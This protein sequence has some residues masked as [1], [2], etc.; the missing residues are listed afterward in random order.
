MPPDEI[1]VV[2]LN[3]ADAAMKLH[4]VSMRKGRA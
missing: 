3:G 2:S 4:K 1:R